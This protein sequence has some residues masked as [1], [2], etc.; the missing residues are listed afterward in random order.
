MNPD[1]VT[2]PPPPPPTVP[3][4]E[5]ETPPPTPPPTPI[6][7]VPVQSVSTPPPPPPAGVVA[8]PKVKWGKGQLIAGVLIL[9]VLTA[10]LMAG[11]LLSQRNQNVPKSAA[12]VCSP[13]GITERYCS[14]G[15]SV[16]AGNACHTCVNNQWVEDNNCLGLTCDACATGQTCSTGGS[17]GGPTPGTCDALSCQAGTNQFVRHFIC[18]TQLIGGKCD[19]TAP[20]A[21]VVSDTGDNRSLT[22]AA[23]AGQPCTSEQI[24]IFQNIADPYTNNAGFVTDIARNNDFSNCA[25]P[26]PTPQTVPD[27]TNLA[28]ASGSLSSLVAGTQYTFNLTAGGSAPVTDVAIDVVNPAQANYCT[29][30]VIAGNKVPA[31][32]PGTYQLHWTPVS[33][34]NYEVYVQVWNDGVA[35]CRSDCVDGP[36]RFLC[37]HAASCKLNVTVVPGVTVLPTN[38]PTPTPT[39]TPSP[40]PI[41]PT[42][43]GI[44]ACQQVT[45][46]S[47]VRAGTAVA[48]PTLAKIQKGDVVTFRGFATAT[49]AV[50]STIDF[51]LVKG[52][53]TQPVVHKTPTLAAGVYQ[54]DNTITIDQATSYSMSSAPTYQ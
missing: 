52:G 14:S 42:P 23:Y 7:D 48:S 17:T 25:A 13:N 38:T 24:D 32:G 2:P 51:T 27:C 18:S 15:G 37:A 34:G 20:G 40:T 35:E 10:G 44:A 49:N 28:L 5:S 33:V 39:P 54:A 8:K 21:V 6:V 45:V 12:S 9:M 3:P 53:V 46:L 47:I 4:V 30:P 36:P 16:P 11:I 31:S 26:T 41:P 1:S 50:V 22:F 19:L 29:A 43:T